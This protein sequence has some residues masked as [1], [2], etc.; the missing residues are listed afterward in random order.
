MKIDINHP[1]FTNF[2]D[3]V[4]NNIT[5]NVYVDRYFGSTNEQKMAEQLKVIKIMNNSLR[6]NIKLNENEYKSFIGV[7]WKK[8]EEVE[9]YELSAIFKDLLENFD[10]MYEVVKPTKKVSRRITTKNKNE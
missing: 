9:K 1:T 4:I 6:S 2:I 8:S 3:N 5:T 10:G 7:L